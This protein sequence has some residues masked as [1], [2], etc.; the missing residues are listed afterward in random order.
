M[1]HYQKPLRSLSKGRIPFSLSPHVHFTRKYQPAALTPYKVL[2]AMRGMSR[3]NLSGTPPPRAHS[4]LSLNSLPTQASF[5]SLIN[6]IFSVSLDFT[7][8]LFVGGDWSGRNTLL[9][10]ASF[11]TIFPAALPLFRTSF[12]IKYPVQ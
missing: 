11:A 5:K 1:N 8:G 12:L 7:R 9:H 10:R 3:R 6:P 2:M 4:N